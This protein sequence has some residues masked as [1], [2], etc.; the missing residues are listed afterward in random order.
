MSSANN[1]LSDVLVDWS[2]VNGEF[3]VCVFDAV[4]IERRVERLG[5]FEYEAVALTALHKLSCVSCIREACIA[6]T[7]IPSLQHLHPFMSP[8][9]ALCDNPCAAQDAREICLLVLPFNFTYQNFAELSPNV[10]RI[11]SQ[12]RQK[13]VRSK[14]DWY[15]SKLL[16][17]TSAAR[18]ALGEFGATLRRC[19]VGYSR[20]PKASDAS[21]AKDVRR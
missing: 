11:D 8:D 6:R 19:W 5:D 12:S 18:H 2:P 20:R 14:A 1:A 13:L 16:D 3:S 17:A 21:A 7:R 15:P 10:A 4:E 9:A